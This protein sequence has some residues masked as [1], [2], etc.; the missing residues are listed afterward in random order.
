MIMKKRFTLLILLALAIIMGISPVVKAQSF[1]HPGIP[2]TQD[3]LNQ[4]KTNITQEPW[5]S[6]YEALVADYRSNLS[7]GMQGPRA[8]VGRAPDV[9]RSPWI[10]DMIAIHNLA[11]MWIFTENEEY[12][13]KAIGILDSWAVTNVQWSGDETFLDLGDHAHYFITGADILKS[14]YPQGWTSLVNTHVRNYFENVLW[15][16]ADVPYPVRGQNQGAIQLKL[17]IGL[18][19]FL[20]DPVKWQQ[21][22]DVYRSDAGGGLPNS[23]PNG[24]VGDTGRDEG[25]WFG[26][27]DAL[28]WCAEIAWKQGIDVFSELD[29]RMLA[30]S[31]LYTRY[32]VDNTKDTYIPHGGTYGYYNNFGTSGGAR[33]SAFLYNIIAGAYPLRKGTAAPYTLAFRDLVAENALSFLYRKK[34]DNSTATQ[35]SPVTLPATA[36]IKN[37]TS[38]DVGNVGL[39][40]SSEYNA[41]IWEIKGAGKDIPVPPQQEPDAFHYAFQQITNDAVIVTKITSV[42]NNGRAGIMFRNSL[43]EKS[44]YAGIFYAS[45][46]REIDFTFRGSDGW[47]KT[48]TSWNLPPGGYLA[49]GSTLPHWFKLERR[50]NK[51]S[52]YHSHD[53]I[54]W[55]CLGIAAFDNPESAVYVGLCTSSKNTSALCEAV[56]ENVAIS[57][58]APEGSPVI[59]GATSAEA[60]IGNAFNYTIEASNNPVTFNATGLPAGLDINSSTGKI[61]GTPA[62]QGRYLIS[63]SA[64]NATGTGKATLILDVINNAA[65][66]PPLNVTLTHTGL[67]EVLI[68]WSVSENATSYSVKRSLT[69]TNGYTTI[70]S[71]VTDTCFTDATA[72][73]G[74][75]YYMVTANAGNQESADSNEEMISLPPDIPAKPSIIS[76]NGQ[77]TLNWTIATGAQ[78]YH[79]K[80][81]TNPGGPY[82]IIA[83]NVTGISYTDNSVTNGIYYYYVISSIATLESSN[84]Q[85]VLGVPGATV[86]TWS[87][88]PVS[89]KWNNPANWEEGVVP[90][91]P[92][93]I[94]FG[95]SAITTLENDIPAGLEIARITFNNGAS[96]YA[97]SGNSITLKN[98]VNNNSTSAQ[99]INLAVEINSMVEINVSS[100]DISLGGII[101]GTGGL[102]KQGFNSLNI[103]GDNT[104]SGG[105]IIY[106]S[107]GG[108]GP[109]APLNITGSGAISNGI[110]TYGPLGTGDVTL[111]G[112]ALRNSGAARLYNDII[113]EENTKSYLY[114][115]GGALTFEGGFKGKGIVEHDG[116]SYDGLHLNGDNSD[117]EGTFISKTRSS[118]CRIRINNAKAG[119]K[120]ATWIL[121]SNFSD[122]HRFSDTSSPYYFGELSGTGL[123]NTYASTELEIGHLN[124][125]SEF[126]GTTSGTNAKLTKV[127]TG[128]LLLSGI[129]SHY[130]NST[131][132]EGKIIVT[133]SLASP[134]VVNSGGTFGG[135]GTGTAN[136]SVNSGGYFAPGNDNIGTYTTSGQII[137]NAGSTYLVETNAGYN[138]VIETEGVTI[139]NNAI[140]SIVNLNSNE[141]TEG[142][143]IK[144][145][146][147]TGTSPVTG[148]FKD[149]PEF[150]LL[151]IGT[152]QFRITYEGGDGNDIVLLDNR[153]VANGTPAAP[154]NILGIALSSSQIKINWDASPVSEY[155]KSYTIKRADNISGPY[156]T[157]ASN[158]KTIEY[159]DKNLTAN[160]PYYYKI[161]ATNFM[162][163]G[164]E[165]APQTFSTLPLTTPH[166]PTGIKTSTG[167]NQISLNWKSAYEATSY[168]VKRSTTSGGSYT[169]IAN[170]TDTTYNDITATNGTTY[171][172][173][174]SSRNA[175]YESGNSIEVSA[176]PS[177]DAWSYWP[178]NE[179]SGTTATDIWNGRNATINGGT[180]VQGIDQ[181]GVLLDGS[182]SSY[183]QMPNG[184]INTLSDFTVSAWVKLDAQGNWARIW[185]FGRGTTHYMFLTSNTGSATSSIRFAIKAGNSE[186]VIYG[187]HVLQVG[188]WTHI[189]VTKSGT[190]GVMYVN[191]IEEGRNTSMTLKPSDLGALNQNY[192]GKSQYTADAMLKGT[193]DDIRIYSKALSAFEIAELITLVA[194]DAPANLTATMISGKAVLNWDQVTGSES[195][196]VKRATISGGPYTTIKTDVTANTYT[197]ATATNGTYY[198]I[199]TASANNIEGLASNEA[200]VTLKPA[201]PT[202]GIALGWNNRVDLN[203][204]ASAGAASYNIKRATTSG[205]PYTIVGDTTACEFRDKNNLTNDTTYYYVISAVNAGGESDN[206]A[207]VTGKPVDKPVY[208]IW[209]HSDIGDTGLT[210]N[211]GFDENTFTMYGAGSDIWGNADGFQFVYRKVSGDVTII[212]KVETL[213]NTHA[214]AKAG[215]MIRQSLDANS[216]NAMS[217]LIPG[218]NLE[219]GY[220][221]STGGSSTNTALAGGTAPQWVKLVRS[222]NTFNAYRSEDGIT[223]SIH[224]ASPTINMTGDIYVGVVAVSHNTSALTKATFG[225]IS[226]ANDLPVISGPLTTEGELGDRFSYQ[227][228]ASGEPHYFNATGLPAGLNI[229]KNS[230]IISGNPTELGTFDMTIDVLNPLGGDTTSLSITVTNLSKPENLCAYAVSGTVE[231]SWDNV[232]GSVKAYNIKRSKTVGGP[233]VTIATNVMA[234]NYIDTTVTN[235]VYYYTVA[236]TVNN[237]EGPSSS[238]K[239]ASLSPLIP[240]SGIALGWNERIDISWKAAEEALSYNIKRATVSG[241]PYTQI[242]NV[243]TCEFSD[244]VGLSN[245]VPYYYVISAVGTGGESD[246]SVEFTGQPVDNSEFDIWTH[247]DI[248]STGLTGNA[249]FDENTFTV[250]GAGS[251]IG[252]T[253]DAFRFVHQKMNG[254]V[255]I[256]AKVESL[257]QTHT[258][259]KGGVMIRQSLDDNSIHAMST[260]TPEG[261]LEFGNRISIGNHSTCMSLS[262]DQVPH[263]VK[264]IRTGDIFTAYRSA[265]GITWST[266]D[267]SSA[268]TMTGDIYVGILAV[269]RN[270]NALTKVCYGNIAISTAL[271]EISGP[272]SANGKLDDSFSYSIDASENPYYY[273]ATGLPAGLSI[274]NETGEISGIPT[275]KGTFDVTVKA[276]NVMGEDIRTLTIS[277]S[278]IITGIDATVPGSWNIYPNPVKDKL[279]IVFG[280][281]NDVFREIRI[282]DLNGQ[283]KVIKKANNEATCILNMENLPA[284][285]YVLKI[286]ENGIIRSEKL[287]KL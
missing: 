126:S 155:V 138:D 47:S 224:S 260:I 131:V 251:D 52:G 263:W 1:V 50:D 113:F 158:L 79:V 22:I 205:G 233:Y 283:V 124:T 203:W 229:D 142:T 243:T 74:D 133:G 78:S 5:K 232:P 192:I 259:A 174:I 262:G 64:G 274:D 81:S 239:Y 109:N 227:I 54:S 11:F 222:G 179:G 102:T 7:Y 43:D 145:I 112:G 13:Q 143:Q 40:G 24:Q 67:N 121:N 255:A 33:R 96:A 161:S 286:N 23:L 265:D 66:L 160:T 159:T 170:V 87:P 190:L 103:S 173:V 235:G 226:I 273:D 80:R 110:I 213:Q 236:A 63:L 115:E 62:T 132:N 186:Q 271:P 181:G 276:L 9:N 225:N 28:A 266:H 269:S 10:N 117:F 19:V 93:F 195:Y 172:Y 280:Q 17:A 171:Y 217:A 215:V 95:T 240:T 68:S 231:L 88:N 100:G 83:S 267:S 228:T 177:A 14:T 26:Q 167:F 59:T 272:L 200:S 196:S 163:E 29:N 257:T 130:G 242:G 193:V 146:D 268:I 148:T 111:T 220:R 69:S 31:E 191:G 144:I 25:H 214:S 248:G 149:L 136:V 21:V 37:L 107:N 244:K 116:N 156:Q 189:T 212:A 139:N 99:I 207:E 180:W 106:D 55:T 49:H 60:I 101:S 76:Q 169:T 211:A 72:Y 234:N 252:G 168:D 246:N 282:T 250:Y 15:P 166:I 8:I 97:I 36:E 284:G 44:K 90:T 92:A 3:D 61:T 285:T 206:S 84:S 91:S 238:E 45:S 209:N 219:F 77:I 150:A 258:L 152:N 85:E 197:D 2:F 34:T 178:L 48:A 153:S 118:W 194:P 210:G 46:N 264:L 261:N 73:P 256:M 125:D 129:L 198:Y 41:G 151:T 202:S 119:S 187:S 184:F 135:T 18:A 154:V 188:K 221:T 140:L 134:V 42:G 89:G 237:I 27:A 12:A 123:L 185:D 253:S 20:D 75:N 38:V 141:Y 201:V 218:G 6:A 82:A 279:T 247:A 57:R 4:L 164:T 287:I 104:Y 278:D 51:I 71:N 216:I 122:N 175:L 58:M 157:I 127:G 39:S 147:N 70:A 165:S 176:T 94:I 277:I 53:G 204:K 245:G 108:W 65:P 114:S 249:G 32:M 183:I 120:K 254:D 223:W 137:F 86:A 105:T 182:S 30:I 270:T 16:H 281:N 199:V 208:N 35:L 275:E 241:G 162:G 56:F 230:G 128:K 98:Q